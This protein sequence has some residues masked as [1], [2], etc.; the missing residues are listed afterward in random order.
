MTSIKIALVIGW[1]SV[2]CAAALGLLQVLNRE[3]IEID[4]VVGSGGGSIFAGLIAQGYNAAQIIEMNAKLWTHEVTSKNQPGAALR[5]F[6]PSAF[7]RSDYYSLKD[8]TLLNE[9]LKDA[10][11]THE[12]GDTKIPLRISTTDYLTGESAVLSEGR[13]VDAVRASIALP[14]I[15]P[16]VPKDDKLLVD[17]FLSDPFPVG[18]AVQEGADIILAIGF[19]SVFH[20]PI[21][22]LSEYLVHLSGILSNNLFQASF[23]FYN[24]AHHSEIIPIVPDL[25]PSIHLF[26]T[27]RVPEIIEAGAAEGE[28]HLPFLKAMLEARDAG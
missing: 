27:A 26:D 1:G 22:T 16:P 3:G 14:M 12:F 15:F 5:Y 8:D 13:I 2:K 28:K 23:S 24:L 18:V 11:G 9:R 4:L 20:Q 21:T 7:K 10:F 25:D 6:L 19:N 17:G